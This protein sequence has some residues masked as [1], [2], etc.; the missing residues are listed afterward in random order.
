MV[1]PIELISFLFNT[2][3]QEKELLIVRWYQKFAIIHI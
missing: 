3:Q 1:S 2:H